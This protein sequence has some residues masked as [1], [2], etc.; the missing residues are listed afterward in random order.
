MF[1]DLFYIITLSQISGKAKCVN[2]TDFDFTPVKH[3]LEIPET[4][5]Y[6]Y[7]VDGDTV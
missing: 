1:N 7:R 4:N 5:K 6:A 2:I 3:Y